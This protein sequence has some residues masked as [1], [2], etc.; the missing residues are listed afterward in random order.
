MQEESNVLSREE[1]RVSQLGLKCC[2]S[3]EE[4]NF[5]ATVFQLQPRIPDVIG[6]KRKAFAHALYRC[7][8]R[9]VHSALYEVFGQHTGAL[10]R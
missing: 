7:D 9:P 3:F 6:I 8:L 4:D 5:A 1:V 2:R 10:A